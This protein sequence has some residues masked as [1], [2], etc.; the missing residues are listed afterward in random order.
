MSAPAEA[1]P[2]ESTA[3]LHV[4]LTL[5]M[6][7]VLC[8]AIF[9]V[10]KKLGIDP[11]PP[12]RAR[13]WG[14]PSRPSAA[15]VDARAAKPQQGKPFADGLRLYTR[16]EVAVHNNE[17]DLWL[18]LAIRGDGRLGVYDLTDY[19]PDHPGGE[20]ILKD[21]GKDATLG[22][23]GPQHPPT[24]HELVLAYHIGFVDDGEGNPERAKEE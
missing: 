18:I 24:V 20:T 22:F 5:I 11:S 6:T 13:S 12:R 7:V 16:E 15:V 17:D 3:M 21:A 1:A 8:T 14:A 2:V 4:T 9:V 19:I 23:N 10:L